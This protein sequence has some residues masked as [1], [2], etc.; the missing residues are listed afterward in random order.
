MSSPLAACGAVL[1]VLAIVGLARGWDAEQEAA[2]RAEAPRWTPPDGGPPPDAG[3]STEQIARLLAEQPM[4]VNRASA[5][6]LELL[7]RI[8]PTLARRVIEER[9]RGGPFESVEALTRVR[10][11]GP[12]TVEQL[13][14]LAVA[15]PVGPASTEAVT[16]SSSPERAQ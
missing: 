4:D 16:E 9:D 12:R 7:P 5:A 3:L 1:V 6:E 15:G 13:A 10:G 14:H 8:G 2:A 11:I